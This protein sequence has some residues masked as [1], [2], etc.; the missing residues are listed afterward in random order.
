MRDKFYHVGI[1]FCCCARHEASDATA[2]LR[3]GANSPTLSAM[4]CPGA[5][6]VFLCPINF[7]PG[8]AN[9]VALKLKLPKR[10]PDQQEGDSCRYGWLALQHYNDGYW[11]RE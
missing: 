8:G 5:T 4:I 2:V 9:G 11:E 10:L 1:N 7:V 6:I 3:T